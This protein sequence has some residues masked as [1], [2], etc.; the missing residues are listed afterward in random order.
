MDCESEKVERAPAA[1]L[2]R[3]SFS[4]RGRF[5]R[6]R[7]MFAAG[8]ELGFRCFEISGIDRD[9]FSGKI[10]PSDFSHQ[11]PRSRAARARAHARWFARTRNRVISTTGV[12]EIQAI[13]FDMGGTL[14]A[15]IPDQDVQRNARARLAEL[16]DRA[17]APD[18]LLQELAQR[19]QSYTRWAQENLV[20]SSEKEIWTRWMLPEYPRERI[21]P[22]AE[23]LTLLWRERSGRTVPKPDARQVIAELSQRGYRLGLISNTI[24]SVDTPR[25]LDEY[26]LKG[27]FEI[28]ILSSLSGHRK[29][30]PEIFW[31]GTREM[32]VDPARCAYVGDRIS[33]DVVGAK[34]ADFAMAIIIEPLGAPR[35]DERDAVYK[36]D[37]IIHALS[38]L[39][40]IFP[41]R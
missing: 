22:M 15:R 34:R 10:H 9:T 37:A 4:L 20:E 40:D 11:S 39:L 6:P 27:Y 26:G 38:D 21:A 8:V 32:R 29:P 36:P 2:A 28:V 31:Q 12:R 1:A 19:F 23:T 7:D 18:D 17:D 13:F 25:R 3:S 41:A 35:E 14:H 5:E 24:S 30:D 16:L 33:R